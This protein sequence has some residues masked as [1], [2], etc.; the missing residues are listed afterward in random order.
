MG[1][2]AH[3]L[4]GLQLPGRRAAASMLNESGEVLAL[5]SLAGDVL[6]AGI[7]RCAGGVQP[8]PVAVLGGHDAVGGHED[9]AAEGLELLLLLPPGVA[10]VAHEV[11]V[12][13]EGGVVV[14]GE[15]LGVGVHVH[16]GALGLLQQ[17]LQVPQVVAGDQ[18]AGV[19]AHADVDPGDLGIAVGGGVGLVQEGHALHAVLARLQGQGGELVAGEAVVQGGGQ[20]LLQEGVHRGV[21]LAQ[22]ICVLGVGGQALQAVGDELP[23]GADVLIFGGEDAHGLGFLRPVAGAVPQSGLRQGGQVAQLLPQPLQDVQGLPDAGVDGVGVKVGV[24][25]GGEEVD[26]DEPVHLRRHRPAPGAQGGGHGGEPPGHKNKQILPVGHLRRLSAHTCPGAAGAA[27]GLLALVAKHR[28]F[29]IRYPSVISPACDGSGRRSGGILSGP[30][31]FVCCYSNKKRRKS[32]PAAARAG[33]QAA[34]ITFLVP[35]NL[36]KVWRWGY[37]STH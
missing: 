35:L 13:L 24:G 22:G 5:P 31:S 10:V 28:V 8:V 17:Q 30:P 6:T 2:A 14:G 9:G 34:S 36:D 32:V 21:G 4:A 18:N 29:H 11:G 25:D 20:G 37:T 1:E 12:L 16:P 33:N 19:P 26:G 3:D 15:H 23:Q 27:G 7:A